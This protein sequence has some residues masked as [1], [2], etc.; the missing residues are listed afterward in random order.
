METMKIAIIG[1]GNVGG[2]LGPRWAEA[3][4]EVIYG[5][6]DPEGAKVQE[7]VAESGGR[8]R[9]D[10][11]RDAV[12][13]GD[14]VILA[15]PWD[16]TEGVISEAGDLAG[17]ILVDCTNPIAA[18]LRGLTLGHT[19]SAGE[20]V[21]GWARGARVV[22]AFNTTGSGNMALPSYGQLKMTMFVC[23]DDQEA[24]QIVAALAEQ[25]GFASVVTGPLYHARY[26]EPL[27]MLWVD[28]AYA[29]GRGPDFAYCLLER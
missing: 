22:K 16:V 12:A 26:L 1:T 25:L 27:A 20:Q 17:K 3:G 5:S 23:G 10:T 15:I 8:S 19:I 24:N 13:A 28:M 7:L 14:I 6:R 2:T 18:N 9:A 21:A 29:Q 4:H 11:V